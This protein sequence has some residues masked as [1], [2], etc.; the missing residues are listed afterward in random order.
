MIIVGLL[1]TLV[2]F[3]ALIKR[4]ADVGQLMPPLVGPSGADPAISIYRL[5]DGSFLECGTRNGQ[6][7]CQIIAAD[8]GVSM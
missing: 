4:D 1:T 7:D 3:L 6:Y 8:G 5:A 2:I